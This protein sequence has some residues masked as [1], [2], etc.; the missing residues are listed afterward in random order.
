MKL[1]PFVLLLVL[2]ARPG[3]PLRAQIPA[4]LNPEQVRAEVIRRGFDPAEVEMRM[5]ARGFDPQTVSQAQLPAARQALAEVLSELE[6]EKQAATAPPLPV[7]RDTIVP[8]SK[9]L[10]AAPPPA[11]S[12][13]GRSVLSPGAQYPVTTFGQQVFRDRSLAVYRQTAD[14]TVP[15]DYVLGPGDQLVVS[16]WGQMTAYNEDLTINNEGYATPRSLSR[17]YLTGLTFA[18][19]R[20]QLQAVFARRY[21]VDRANFAVSLSVART[22]DVNVTGEVFHYGTFRLSALNTAFNALV[23][24]G[25]PTD[26][27]SVREITLFR[28]GQPPRRIDVYQYLLNPAEA[29]QFYLQNGDNL[30]VP[31][32]G[33]VVRIDGA[34]KRPARY[35]LIKGE[36]LRRLIDWAGGL[37]GDAYTASVQIARTTNQQNVLLDVNLAEL[38]D[39]NSDFELFDGDVITLRALAAPADNFVTVEG[40]V[41]FAGNYAFSNGLKISDLLARSRLR[42]EARGDFAYLQRSRP[43]GTVAYISV[44]PAEALSDPAGGANLPLQARDRLIIFEQNRFADAATLQ[45]EGAVRD[46]RTLPFDAGRQLRVRDLIELSGG[47]RPDAADFAYLVRTAPDNPEQKSYVRL[48]LPRLMADPA[49]PANIPL[50]PFDRLL[51]QSKTLFTDVFTVQV[52]GAVRN[53]GDYQWSESLRMQD[54]L[55]LAGGLRPEAAS[56]RIDVFRIVL[57]QNE[58]T[59]VV[60]GTFTLDS[61]YQV[62]NAASFYLQPYDIVV[63][64]AVP[65]F[66][67]QKMVT[68]RGEVRYPGEYALIDKNEQLLS[69]LQRA[70]GLTGEAFPAGATLFRS[71]GQTGY[72]VL[73]LDDVLRNPADR[74]NFVLKAGD[75]I[76]IPKAKDL[77]AIRGATRAFDLYPDKVI[78]NGGGIHVAYRPGRRAGWYVRQYAAG[79]GDRALRRSLTVEEANGRLRR[80]KNFGLFRIYPPV[81]KG[82]TINVARKPPEEP[83][84]EGPKKEVDWEVVFAET[85]AKATSVLTLLVLLQ[86]L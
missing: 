75:L 34:V 57:N 12:L 18:Q 60:V 8:G 66:E 21:P 2:A 81:S 68:L 11:D 76:E 56:N 5:R 61:S 65:A 17:V 71:E 80:T 26:I 54:V 86:R 84:L 23:A 30:F 79:F 82:A 73:R 24:T 35:E 28:G 4:T 16:I 41:E 6:A 62:Q 58:P 78:G 44:R 14:L 37:R 47:L 32:A 10:T 13:P 3:L 72:V 63:V 15:D 33:R 20:Q 31:V 45:S 7:P 43:D 42:R 83:R 74:H 64:R 9:P 49:A 40:A 22:V 50:E 25:G 85:I 51:V 39:Q 77:V 69:V 52:K 19:A 67:L 55:S 53:P 38:I 48:D 70:G 59:S 46:P 1:F 27:G 29:Q 36:N